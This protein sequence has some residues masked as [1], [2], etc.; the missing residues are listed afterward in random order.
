M[1]KKAI[2]ER[3]VKRIFDVVV[4]GF[5]LIILAPFFILIAL[6]LKLEGLMNP[7]LRGPVFYKEIRISKGKPFNIYKF[8]AV[9][10]NILE[11]VKKEKVSIT[12]FTA[13]RN[14]SKYLTPV[15]VFLAQIY[16]DELPQFFN[17]LKGDMSLVGPRPH[18]PEHY[19]SD[20]REGIVAA[21]YI[22]AGVMGLVQ[23]SKGNSKMRNALARMATKHAIKNKTIV[24]IDRLYFQ[25]YLK[26]SAIE[27]LFYDIGIMFQCLRV[28]LEAKGI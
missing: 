28:V 12:E 25:K 18:V 21:K 5:F 8:R 3:I 11:L 26:A 2:N 9:R 10:Y 7:S 22:K 14:K 16:F 1:K 17:V 24:F 23:G 6:L 27:M 15:G 4:S 20:L 19:A 13:K